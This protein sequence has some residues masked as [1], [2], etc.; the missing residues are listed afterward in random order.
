MFRYSLFELL[1]FLVLLMILSSAVFHLMP[2][3]NRNPDWK[4]KFVKQVNY[5]YQIR[6]IRP[7]C[8][9]HSGPGLPWDDEILG[10][11][12]EVAILWD[13]RACPGSALNF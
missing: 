3:P 8:L 2:G 4:G 6:C 11:M 1:A 10:P 7:A 5:H 12:L 13:M 9:E